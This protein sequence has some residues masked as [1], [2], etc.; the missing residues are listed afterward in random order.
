MSHLSIMHF[1]HR[2]RNSSTLEFREVVID[3][4]KENAGEANRH[5]HFNPLPIKAQPRLL[6][7]YLYS[8]NNLSQQF[9]YP[10]RQGMHIA[11]CK[12]KGVLCSYVSSNSQY[13]PYAHADKPST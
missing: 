7:T 1:I 9:A 2:I 4:G 11:F 6:F 10:V 5:A 13:M 3:V 12:A 8:L